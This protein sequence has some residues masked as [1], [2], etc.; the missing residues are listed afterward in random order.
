M[1]KFSLKVS[2]IV[3]IRVSASKLFDSDQIRASLAFRLAKFQKQVIDNYN[4][5]VE[6]RDAALKKYGKPGERPGTYEFE[7]DAQEKFE[8]ENKELLGLEI[9][10]ESD[11]FKLEEFGDV[12]GIPASAFTTFL[13]VGIIVDN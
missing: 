7:L 5:Y 13:R 8:S 6:K 11:Q 1:A 4:N 9:E 12:I 10:V 3:D 2:D